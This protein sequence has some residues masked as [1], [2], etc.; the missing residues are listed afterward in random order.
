MKP[1]PSGIQ[2]LLITAKFSPE[3][4]GV[5]AVAEALASHLSQHIAVV[6][7]KAQSKPQRIPDWHVFDQRFSFPV[8]RL[9]A[10]ETE[11]SPR[12]PRRLRGAL[13]FAYN[14]LWT[15]PLVLFFLY[16]ILQRHPVP[17]ICINS[18]SCY[19]VSM[20][21]RVKPDLKIVFYLHGEE[22]NDG[23]KRRKMD[24]LAQKSLRKGDAVIAVSS[25]TRDRALRCGVSPERL[26]VIHNGVNTSRFSPGPR[27]PAI[28]ER[29]ALKGKSVL[30]CL[31]RL[32][33]RKG[34]DK[35]L[36]AMP[37]IL[38]A[39][40][41]AVL[42]IVGGGD[43][44]SPLRELAGT[45]GLKERVIFA[46]AAS[47]AE[48]TAYYRTADVYVMPNRTTASGDTEGFGLVFLEAGACGNP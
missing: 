40:P 23:P 35:L 10:F 12:L 8:Y 6:A 20:L 13:Q 19:W 45:L 42:L 43:Y 28:E 16:K 18:L 46:G 25:F 15:R 30:L 37:E 33:E 5:C 26:T 44:E 17:V 2:I 27:D 32:D 48:L 47:D 9:G 29:F 4:G 7:P 14:A 31:A 21:K 39:V 1:N 38:T 41:Q 36:E 22:V 34:Q 11:L 3:I 24:D